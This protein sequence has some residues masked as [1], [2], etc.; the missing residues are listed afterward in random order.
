MLPE[1][2]WVDP[3]ERPKM[4]AEIRAIKI[5]SIDQ[6]N[7]MLSV[8]ADTPWHYLA[9]EKANEFVAKKRVEGYFANV[10]RFCMYR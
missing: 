3:I 9:V 7:F 5:E 4:E 1:E 6:V 8:W 10:S 2:R